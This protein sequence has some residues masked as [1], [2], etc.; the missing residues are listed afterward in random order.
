MMNVLIAVGVEA[1]SNFFGED[2]EKLQGK[3]KRGAKKFGFG[4]C[5]SDT[6]GYFS[7]HTWRPM[8]Q[9][10]KVLWPDLCLGQLAFKHSV[11][12]R[13]H[14]HPQATHGASAWQWGVP[15]AT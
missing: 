6:S 8:L 5:V 7:R 4:G 12:F 3:Q 15:M 2:G 11:A 1:R 13:T 9:T 10:F 14:P